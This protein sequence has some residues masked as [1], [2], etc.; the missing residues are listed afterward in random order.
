[1]DSNQEH[2]KN[3][4]EI[5]SLM[6]RS[7]S[8]LSLSGLSGISAGVIGLITTAILHY[9]IGPY[10]VFDNFLPVIASVERRSDLVLFCVILFTFVLIATFSAAAFFTM[11]KARKK[12]LNV[13][14]ASAKKLVVNLFIPL[15]IG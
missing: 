3:L 5:R 9:K 6:E 7:S 12:G 1:M 10:M 2:L 4:N 11:R 14:D 8:F 15:L 13:W